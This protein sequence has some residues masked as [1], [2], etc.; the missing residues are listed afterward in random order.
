MNHW[1]NI[2]LENLYEVHEGILYTEEW[3]AINGYENIYEVSTFGRIKTLSRQ[4]ILNT[5]KG[6]GTKYMSNEKILKQSKSTFGYPVV[7]LRKKN[8][9]KTIFV[10]VLVGETFIPN[11]ESK[12]VINHKK[13][14]KTD[15]R[16][17][18]LEWNTHSEN[19]QHAFKIGLKK[20]PKG[21]DHYR[22]TKIKNKV[23]GIIY[24]SLKEAALKENIKYATMKSRLFQKHKNYEYV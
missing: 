23:T 8:K 21:D 11:P 3:R 10:H 24:N 15:N 7:V 12:P 19:V 17:H 20:A 22:I 16:I 5:P 4:R 18:Q 1:Q 9:P 2:S 14:I 13:G 6:Y